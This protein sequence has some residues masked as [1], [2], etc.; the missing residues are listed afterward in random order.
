MGLENGFQSV[1]IRN[2]V[3]CVVGVWSAIRNCVAPNKEKETKQ[4]AKVA[5]TSKGRSNTLSGVN[6]T[7]GRVCDCN[8]DER[9]MTIQ[10]NEHMIGIMPLLYEKYESY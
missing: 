4:D 5:G 8:S 9:T 2:I 1:E 7:T 6:P 3:D 10:T